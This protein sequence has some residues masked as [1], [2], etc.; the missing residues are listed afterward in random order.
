MN[1]DERKS[2]RRHRGFNFFDPDDEK[3]FRTLGSVEFNTSGF[4]NRD[5]RRRLL[6]PGS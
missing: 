5:L 2:V 4:Q 3:L 1:V 6:S